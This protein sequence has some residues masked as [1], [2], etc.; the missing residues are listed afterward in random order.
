[1]TSRQNLEEKVFKVLNKKRYL[2]VLDDIW[3]TEVWDDLKALFQDVK[4]ASRVGTEMWSY[5][6]IPGAPPTNYTLIPEPGAFP[7][8]GLSPGR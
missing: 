8:K 6:L 7:E 2:I 1:M 3:E 4:N 5:M